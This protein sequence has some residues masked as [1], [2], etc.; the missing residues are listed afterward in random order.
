MRH[1][2][3]IAETRNNFRIFLKDRLALVG[4]AWIILTLAL[5]IFAPV[6]PYPAQGAGPPTWPPPPGTQLALLS[7]PTN[8]GGTF[9]VASSTA[10][11]LPS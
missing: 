4:L 3:A 10:R 6:V 11:A 1:A 5:A 8:W 2:P 9:S 7:V